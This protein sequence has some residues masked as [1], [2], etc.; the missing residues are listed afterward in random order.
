MKKTFLLFILFSGIA[1]S[2]DLYTSP[3]KI[4]L[5]LSAGVAPQSIGYTNHFFCWGA[6]AIYTI[7]NQYL[8]L[9]YNQTLAFDMVSSENE[10]YDDS[11]IH[12]IE[13]VYGRITNLSNTHKLFR[14]F[15]YGA[16][17][18][19]T[20][21]NIGYYTKDYHDYPKSSQTVTRMGIPIGI[22]GS[23]SFNSW[24]HLG[25]EFKYHI[26]I[27]GQRFVEYNFFLMFSL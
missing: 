12:R 21:N 6:K 27:R 11:K 16:M 15:Y 8:R 26:L 10:P 3:G 1:Y 14:H 19:I 2:Q 5:G 17:I 13:L 7:D 25:W 18:G 20:Y 24:I 9:S 23:N 4:Y 22:T